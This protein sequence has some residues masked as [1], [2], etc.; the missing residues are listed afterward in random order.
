M[1]DNNSFVLELHLGPRYKHDGCSSC[2]YLGRF[3]DYDLYYCEGIT[4]KTVLARYSSEP[5]EYLSGWG[6]YMVPLMIAEAMAYR[7]NFVGKD[8]IG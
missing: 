5:S 4:T 6:L 7:K 1:P 3:K 8:K 2:Q